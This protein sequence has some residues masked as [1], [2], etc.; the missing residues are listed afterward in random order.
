MNFTAII[1]ARVGS[2]RLKKKILRKIGKKTVIEI[3]LERLKYSKKINKI[4]IAIPNT[5]Q[6]DSLFKKLKKLNYEVFR[7]DENNVLKRYYDCAKKFKIDN[8][9]RITSDCPLIDP[10]LIDNGIHLFKKNNIDYLSNVLTLSFPD[11]LDF[12]IFSFKALKKSMDEYLSKSEKEHVTQHMIRSNKIKKLNLNSEENFSN[13]RLTLDYEVD[14]LV[15]K[16]IISN[17]KNLK[18]NYN[19]I[20]GLYKSNKK[21]FHSNIEKIRNES[22]L[23]NKGQVYWERAK[24]IIPGGTHLFSK[25]P[26]NFLP[27]LWPVYYSKAKGCKIWDLENNK[28]SD[29]CSMGLGTNLLGYSN[30]KVDNFVIEKLKQSNVS[31]LNSLEDYFLAEKLIKI[32]PWFDMVR[33]TR[34]GGEANSVAVRIARA[35]TGKDKIAFCGYHGWH[36]WYLSSNINKKTNLNNLLMEGLSPSGVPKNLKNTSF[37]FFYNDFESLE[38]IVSQ[39]SDI[40]IIKMEVMRNI[41]PKNQFLKK[42]R[43]LANKKNIVLIFDECT[44]GFRGNLGGLHKKYGVIPDM[45]IFGKA[46]GNGYP[47]NA[48]LGKKEVMEGAQKTFISSTFWTER[49][50]PSAALKTISEME[51]TK[52]W[53]TII[54][55]NKLIR[56]KWKQIAKEN[57][58]K[59]QI[60]GMVGIPSFRIHHKDWNLFKTYITQEMLLKKILATN[61]IYISTAHNNKNLSNYF[62]ELDLNFKKIKKCIDDELNIDKILKVPESKTGFYRL[63]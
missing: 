50:G 6:N 9:I 47:I 8:I 16:K 36:D 34:T 2:K 43:A 62:E 1:Q 28:Y 59:I 18:F 30:K 20:I 55:T 45:V 10:E 24:K 5:K 3:L 48:I 37:P 27:R 7:G 15:I 21:I 4:I 44:S 14:F 57:N 58:I 33:F 22:L 49:L 40:G 35:A 32:H 19:D 23:N 39:N 60:D 31:T 41:E 12:E 61:S 42:V 54:K 29:L 17:F 63:N 46:L 38:K 13:L 25:R 53:E 26:D 11:G 52:S 56:S 51:K